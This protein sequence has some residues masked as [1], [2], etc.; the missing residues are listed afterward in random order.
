TASADDLQQIEQRSTRL[1]VQDDDAGIDSGSDDFQDAKDT[2]FEPEKESEI[3]ERTRSPL[4]KVPEGE[5]CCLVMSSFYMYY[6][7]QEKFILQ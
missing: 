6:T 2:S 4:N 3:L 5:Y 1:F 7:M